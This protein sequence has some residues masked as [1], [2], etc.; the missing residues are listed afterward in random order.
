[1]QNYIA[2]VAPTEEGLLKELEMCRERLK[3]AGDVFRVTGRKAVDPELSKLVQP[4]PGIGVQTAASL[5]AELGGIS[6]FKDAKA[7]VAYMELKTKRYDTCPQRET[8]ETR[9]AVPSLATKQYPESVISN[10]ALLF[11]FVKLNLVVEV[12]FNLFEYVPFH[13]F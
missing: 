5:I 12:P 3:T 9:F 10:S 4:I 13:F 1:M 7:V 11:N 6:C 8:Y 2:M